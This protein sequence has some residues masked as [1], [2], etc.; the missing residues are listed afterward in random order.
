M[1]PFVMTTDVSLKPNIILLHIGTNDTYMT[2]QPQAQAPMRLQSLVDLILSTYPNALLVVAKI[3]PYPSQT[4]NV[5]LINDS[6]PNLV[7]SRAAMGKHI[8]TVDMNTGFNVQ[9]WLSSDTIHPNMN[10][11]NWMGDQW[12]SVV[13]SYFH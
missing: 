11:Y 2:G 12:Y 13:G 7:S 10:G 1:R 5:K 3:I 4:S 8:L 9:S 6:I